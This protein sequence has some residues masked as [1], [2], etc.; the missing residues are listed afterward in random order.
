MELRIWLL[1]VL[2]MLFSLAVIIA[3]R[4]VVILSKHVKCLEDTVAWQD[5]RLYDLSKSMDAP[6]QERYATRRAARKITI[7]GEVTG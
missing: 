7:S 3:I 5:E 6:S 2:V 1:L 4:A